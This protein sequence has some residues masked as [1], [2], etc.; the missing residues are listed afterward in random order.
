MKKVK[1]TGPH[2][3][4]GSRISSKHQITIPAK[5]LRAAGLSIGERLVARVEGPGRVV[6]ER[7][8]DL[9]AEYAGVLTGVYEADELSHLRDEWD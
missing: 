8:D 1:D 4:P 7:A 6:L 9:L 5:A 2:R 3:P